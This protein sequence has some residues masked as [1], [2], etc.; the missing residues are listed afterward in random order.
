MMSIAQ[1][2]HYH[3]KNQAQKKHRSPEAQKYICY[4]WIEG[5]AFTFLFSMIIFLHL[6]LMMD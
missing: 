1:M 5:A 6:A 2:L 3:T 4:M